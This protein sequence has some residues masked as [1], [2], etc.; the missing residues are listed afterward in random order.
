[1]EKLELSSFLVGTTLENGLAASN[2]VEHTLTSN[3][4]PIFIRLRPIKMK[5]L[6]HRDTYSLVCT[7]ALFVTALNRERPKCPSVG[8]RISRTSE[9]SQGESYLA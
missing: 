7:T 2:K 5:C 4:T 6:S 8:G 9:Q 1:M 3:H